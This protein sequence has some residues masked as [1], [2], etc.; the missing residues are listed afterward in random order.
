[1]R[2][3]PAPNGYGDPSVVVDRETDKIFLFYAASINQGFAGGSTGSDPDD[4]NVL[5]A[6]YSV[7]DDN[8]AT[9]THHRITDQIKAGQ[10]TWAGMFAASGEGIQLRQGAHK[11]R[12]IQQ[13]TIR[14]SGGNY[15]V[16][17]YSDDH[18]ATWKASAPVGPGADENKTV[19][20]A[21]GDVL[22]NSRAA[23][24][25]RIA[26]STDGGATYTAF[27]QDTQLPDPANNG[28]IIRAYPDA[29]PGDPKAQILLFSNA[30]NVNVRRNLTVRMS[31][32]SGTTWPVSK[33]VQSGATG[34]S[35]LTPLPDASGELGAGGFGL[36]YER[37]GYRHISFTKFD[38]GWLEGVC[39]K[40]A[41][42]APTAQPVAGIATTVPVTVTNQSGAALPA[43]SLDVAADSRWDA[44]PTAVPAIAAGAIATVN[45]TVTPGASFDT[46]G[47]ELKVTYT[48]GN[49]AASGSGTLM[50]IGGDKKWEWTTGAVLNPAT[51]S[52]IDVT[53][54]LPSVASLAEGVIVA[55]FTQNA[56]ATV[57]T[58]YAATVK[59]AT[60]KGVVLSINGGKPYFEVRTGGTGHV[61]RL[62]PNVTVTNGQRY[63]LAA[64]VN[65]AGAKLYLNG[66]EIATTTT[67]ALM[68]SVQGLDAMSVGSI[69][70][71]RTDPWIF[72]GT[73]H[74]VHVLGP[75]APVPSLEVRPVLDAIYSAGEPGLLDDG[76]QPWVEVYNTGNVAVTGIS[77]AAPA[78]SAGTPR[79]SRATPSRRPT[80]S[81]SESGAIPTPPPAPRQAAPSPHRR[82]CSPSISARSPRMLKPASGSPPARST[83]PR[84]CGCRRSAASVRRPAATSG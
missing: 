41:V 23:P 1:M 18:G 21:N 36:F 31:C 42:G 45:L 3:S 66:A 80:S 56:N 17:V 14:I 73:L 34:Y 15:A 74:S 69:F 26:R 67:S 40:V 48:Q 79:P 70:T 71:S 2:Q 37:E 12:L 51:S 58:L 28:S 52:R 61:I 16:S 13:Y 5:H 43:G 8:G 63:V 4:P 77:V 82:P 68:S 75:V 6:D 35:T 53:S 20:L 38:L 62:A 39:A 50:V 22:L 11:G 59:G 30:N 54:D 60:D 33:V 78:S 19:E 27:T 49:G 7:S 44:T 32:D 29:A 9:W 81:S 83:R 76:I 25:R 65:A 24:Y 47:H 55:D 64:V 72:N 46:R 84:S 57:G 10:T